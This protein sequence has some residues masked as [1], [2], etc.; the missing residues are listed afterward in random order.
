MLGSVHEKTV[1]LLLGDAKLLQVSG[2]YFTFA[3]QV[4]KFL[5]HGF[6]CSRKKISSFSSLSHQLIPLLLDAL[7]PFDVSLNLQLNLAFLV[8]V[9]AHYTLN[10]STLLHTRCLHHLLLNNQLRLAILAG[11]LKLH[12]LFFKGINK[13]LSPLLQL[14][15]G[16]LSHLT[17]MNIP[18]QV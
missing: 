14:L 11:I 7:L 8:F 15:F 6:F 18:L 3:V 1:I 17:P 9:G 13:I 10:N 4:I 2:L 12:F 5:A 16:S